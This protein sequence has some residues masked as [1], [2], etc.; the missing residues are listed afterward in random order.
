MSSSMV[1]IITSRPAAASNLSLTYP[2]SI[3][4][5]TNIVVEFAHVSSLW[6][7][8]RLYCRYVVLLSD[9]ATIKGL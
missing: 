6:V 4:S 2:Y 7:I 5:F 9:F 1:E 3:T 8:I